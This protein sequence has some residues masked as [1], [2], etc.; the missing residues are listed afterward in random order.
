MLSE[1]ACIGLDVKMYEQIYQL[2]ADENALASFDYD[3][4]AYRWS[5]FYFCEPDDVFQELPFVM[6][7]VGDIILVTDQGNDQYA[8]DQGNCYPAAQVMLGSF[9]NYQGALYPTTCDENNNDRFFMICHTAAEDEL[10]LDSAD[11]SYA[12]SHALTAIGYIRCMTGENAGVR[13]LM[14]IDSDNNAHCYSPV[15]DDAL[16][17]N[18][19]NIYTMYFVEP[20]TLYDCETIALSSYIG[21]K[22]PISSVTLMTSAAE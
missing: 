3:R 13:A 8:D 7:E 16:K 12:G 2:K 9:V 5:D 1:G 19:P 4:Q 6:N 22:A 18:R 20:Y 15:G 21:R 11:S 17:Q 14:I 10:Q